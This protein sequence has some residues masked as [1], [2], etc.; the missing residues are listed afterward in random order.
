MIQMA[1]GEHAT[2]TIRARTGAVRDQG[3]CLDTL[4]CDSIR[5][6]MRA[7]VEVRDQ[8]AILVVQETLRQ[9]SVP[10]SRDVL[11][12]QAHHTDLLPVLTDDGSGGHS[13][14][15]CK[16]HRSE[17]GEIYRQLRTLDI[18]LEEL[19][20]ELQ[21]LE[22]IDENATCGQPTLMV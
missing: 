15:H 21:Q 13:A 12:P 3:K 14:R 8:V 11:Q 10:Y 16:T 6:M 7:I 9:V 17:H 22:G 18:L 1:P 4:L 19:E 20:S 5:A 2:T